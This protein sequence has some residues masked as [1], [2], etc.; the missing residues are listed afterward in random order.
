[1]ASGFV[2]PYGH[3]LFSSFNATSLD[4]VEDDLFYESIEV[5]EYNIYDTFKIE[6]EDFPIIKYEVIA[7]D[8]PEVKTEVIVVDVPKVPVY[9]E[10]VDFFVPT[11]LST[12]KVV[13]KDKETPENKD[14]QEMLI[15]KKEKRRQN[16]NL[17]A[18]RSRKNRIERERYLT[19]EL[20]RLEE[21]NATYT[22]TICGF[23]QILANHVHTI[24]TITIERDHYKSRCE[25]IESAFSLPASKRRH[26][27]MLD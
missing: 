15:Q 3:S 6:Y 5:L 7:D 8:A 13:I 24:E 19:D 12:E 17:A 23:K 1:M 25:S 9:A 11:Y 20:L 18:Q 16:N 14:N 21:K 27:S 26:V 4:Y 22:E 2:L 10:R